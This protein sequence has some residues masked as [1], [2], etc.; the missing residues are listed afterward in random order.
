[1]GTRKAALRSNW[2][3]LRLVFC[4]FVLF[5][6][7]FLKSLLSI[8]YFLHL[9]PRCNT[10]APYYIRIMKYTV[11]YLLTTKEIKYLYPFFFYLFLFLL[12]EG[13]GGGTIQGKSL[14]SKINSYLPPDE[15]IRCDKIKKTTSFT[16]P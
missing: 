10:P 16:A 8:N 5:V 4:L 12:G 9:V 2:I 3:T 1:M 7:F 13:V 15:F 6:C 14:R 11:S